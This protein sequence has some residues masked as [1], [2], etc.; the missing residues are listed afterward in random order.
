[1]ICPDA[2]VAVVY[3]GV[4]GFRE[5]LCIS[6]LCNLTSNQNWETSRDRFLLA[7]AR[8]S[9]TGKA[10][11]RMPLMYFTRQHSLVATLTTRVERLPGWFQLADSV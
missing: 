8:A 2:G 6:S 9:E 11:K 7:T 10:Y 3:L 4:R 1:L 5:A